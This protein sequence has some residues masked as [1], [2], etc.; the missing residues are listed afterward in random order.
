MDRSF[1]SHPEVAVAS[2]K[3]VCIRVISYE[4]ET[5]KAFI[6]TLTN[7]EPSNTA[8]AI[9]TPDGKP[10]ARGRG[11]G[12]GPMDL[13]KD[14]AEMAKGMDA[15]AEKYPLKKVEGVPALPVSLTAKVGLAV[16]A[17]ENQPL[18]VV[19]SD[20]GKQQEEIEAKLAPLAWSKPFDGRF[21]YASTSAAKGVPKSGDFK[22]ASGIAVIEPD[23]FGMGG[24]IVKEIPADQSAT[25]IAE[26]LT[27]A[28][29]SHVVMSKTRRGLHFQG[30]KEGIFYVPNLPV[31][32]RGEAS[33]RERY[34]A[35]LDSQKKN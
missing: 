34:K 9:L 25:K 17:S 4:D 18:V 19:V 11:P 30:L 5:E 33:D 22:I 16:A 12:R 10:A 27:E 28:L 13:Y 14:A 15:I 32:A 29:K 26:A 35:Q 7:R 3:F 20:G 24:K 2:K 6:A 8:F 1:L 31:V 23:T 21:V